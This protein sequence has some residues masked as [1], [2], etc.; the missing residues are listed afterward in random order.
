MVRAWFEH[1]AS[2]P[3]P[4]KSMRHSGMGVLESPRSLN[5]HALS[6][7]PV[8]VCWA[9]LKS[10]EGER[11]CGQSNYTTGWT[12]SLKPARRAPVLPFSTHVRILHLRCM[13]WSDCAVD[14]TPKLEESAMVSLYE[15]CR[16]FGVCEKCLRRFLGPNE[17]SC[18][19]V[20]PS[21]LTTS[22]M[23]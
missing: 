4:E 16:L 9:L 7:T 5:A 18:M 8:K 2:L 11:R 13:A 6:L 3:C 15:T 20:D 17:T 1:G 14:D 12:I 21:L 22:S 23:T 10:G 19:S